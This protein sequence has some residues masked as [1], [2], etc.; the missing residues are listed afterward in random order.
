MSVRSSVIAA[1]AVGLVAASGP[2]AA[3]GA[4]A[5]F[6]LRTVSDLAALCG[7][8]AGEPN[9]E[10]A[11][12][13][14]HGFLT[15]VGQYHAAT[16]RPGTPYPPLFCPPD[17]PPSLGQAAAGFAAWARGN[18]Q[19]AQERAVDGLVRWAQMTYPCSSA[20]GLLR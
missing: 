4:P 1:V 5:S 20:P 18:P 10:A 13:L 11:V 2:A 16:R 9:A 15:G 12:Y 17:P 14:C 3:Q 19:L 7:A 6:Q 8:R